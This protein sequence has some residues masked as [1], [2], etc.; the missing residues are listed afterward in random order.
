MILNYCLHKKVTW[1]VDLTEALDLITIFVIPT[2]KRYF[3]GTYLMIL[4]YATGS[5]AR[6]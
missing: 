3:L 4:R 1:L 6:L 5:A 2:L